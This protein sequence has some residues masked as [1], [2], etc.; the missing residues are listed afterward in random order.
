[1]KLIVFSALASE[2][3]KTLL[4]II[5]IA[6]IFLILESGSVELLRQ[7]MDHHL[8]EWVTEMDRQISVYMK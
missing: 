6:M 7:C 1:M 2:E 5:G 8:N 3:F 4:L